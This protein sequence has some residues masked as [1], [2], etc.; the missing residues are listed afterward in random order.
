MK[1]FRIR[2]FSVSGFKSIASLEKFEPGEVTV[3]IG[4]NGAGKTNIM[5]F[6]KLLKSM[7]GGAG[8]LQEYIAM[9]G[10]ASSFLFDG[11]TATNCIEGRVCMEA[12]DNGENYEYSFVLKHAAGDT[13]IFGE[14]KFMVWSGSKEVS[15]ADLGKGHREAKLTEG[16]GAEAGNFF[17]RQISDHIKAYQLQNTVA[18]SPVRVSKSDVD[19]SWTLDEDGRNIAAVLFELHQNQPAVYRKILLVLKEI[20][21]FFDDFVHQNEYGKIYLRWKEQQSPLT[22][23]A[24]Q[25]SDG[26]LRTI[27]L[28]TLLCM[29]RERQAS[30]IF[31]DEPEL[32]LHPT[33]VRIIGELIQEAAEYVQFFIATQE[34]DLLNMF[35]AEQVVVV[36]RQ[37]RASSFK[38][39]NRKMLEGWIQDYS[40]S[41]LWQHNILGGKP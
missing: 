14:E 26:M 38:R 30:V 10:G 29:P 39:L 1:R 33:A 34:A 8:N 27:I 35:E 23:M 12:M 11:S 41:D 21:P 22:F 17:L 13:L 19:N 20:I 32:G 5:E 37:G 3:L 24:S 40:L 16:I 9:Q 15:A 31:L 4:P 28:V 25:A 7:L 6:F 36:S 18:G 2:H